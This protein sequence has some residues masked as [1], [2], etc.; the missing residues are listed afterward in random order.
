[1]GISNLGQGHFS[2][3]R[4]ETEWNKAALG[5]MA[6]SE[7]GGFMA[8]HDATENDGIQSKYRVDGLKDGQT[9]R[10]VRPV[11]LKAGTPIYKFTGMWDHD[12]NGPLRPGPDLVS[13]M[14][15]FLTTRDNISAWWST[16][17]PFE[18]DTSG[19]YT[20]FQEC[21]LN[22][23][24]GGPGKLTMREWARFMSAVKLE[25]N[26][27]NYY[28][29]LVLASDVEAYWGQFAPQ[30]SINQ[31]EGE[32]ELDILLRRF[33]IKGVTAGKASEQA[34]IEKVG[35]SFFIKYV[36][37][38]ERYYIPNWLGGGGTWQLYIPKFEHSDADLTSIAAVPAS[39]MA[40]LET[41]FTSAAFTAL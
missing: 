23:G 35:D 10:V 20:A 34:S 38:P 5:I 33:G 12:A 19:I 36:G 39:N 6:Q 3:T 7:K 31:V 8:I 27:L 26:T 25:W 17:K 32:S 1:M 41:H 18:E 30:T 13:K 21:K 11:K 40:A 4:G 14:K 28:V 37:D 9:T 22:A 29:Q 2:K 15:A 16:V 24:M